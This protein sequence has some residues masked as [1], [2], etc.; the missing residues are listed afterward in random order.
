MLDVK[1]V[2]CLTA[3]GTRGYPKSEEESQ[4]GLLP[5]LPTAWLVGFLRSCR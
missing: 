2:W 5:E 1:E 4:P 3:T